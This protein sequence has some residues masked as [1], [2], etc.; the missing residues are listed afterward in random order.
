MT[1]ADR[2]VCWLPHDQ[3]LPV[4]WR[5]AEQAASHHAAHGLLIEPDPDNAVAAYAAE[6][7]QTRPVAIVMGD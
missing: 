5:F 2:T 6:V 7:A 4:G 3:D 1:N